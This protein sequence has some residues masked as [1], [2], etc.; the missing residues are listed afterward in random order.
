MHQYLILLPN[1]QANRYYPQLAIYQS[2]RSGLKDLSADD[3]DGA[4][5]QESSMIDFEWQIR[6]SSRRKNLSLCVYSDNRVIVAAPVGLSSKEIAGF[7]ERKS[8]WVRNRL[9]LNREKQEKLP[10]WEFVSG[11]KLP[12]LG[13]EHTLEVCERRG[14]GVSC[15][16]G[17][18]IVSIRPEIPE[19]TRAPFIRRQLVTWYA[20]MALKKVIERVTHYM[21]IIGVTP[22]A[23]RIK[24]LRSRWGSCSAKGGINFA[25]NIILAPEPVLDYLVVH[26]LCHL[27]YHDHSAE[28]WKLVEKFLP[29]HRERR[30]WLREN[31]HCLSF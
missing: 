9:T 30:K 20:N 10:A 14:A 26:E 24:A 17:K 11:E 28:Y 7:V 1:R 31:G 23:V 25:W 13:V 8:D 5:K 16:R 2:K 3:A 27:V 6:R 21:G 12:Y 15:E 4:E 18:I 22:S 19:R 29:E